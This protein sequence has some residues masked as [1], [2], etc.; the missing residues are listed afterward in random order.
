M[1]STGGAPPTD[2][3]KVVDGVDTSPVDELI[4]A[5]ADTIRAAYAYLMNGDEPP[6]KLMV[7][8]FWTQGEQIRPDGSTMLMFTTATEEVT[9]VDPDD[10]WAE[11]P[12]DAPTD[13]YT[14]GP[15]DPGVDAESAQVTPS[16][17]YLP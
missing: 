3:P 16:G 8:V 2:D 1:T 7:D 15:N 14:P 9:V 17:C 10:Y 12:L 13:S 11:P 6:D 4:G 5:V